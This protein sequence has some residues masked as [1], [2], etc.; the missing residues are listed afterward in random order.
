MVRPVITLLIFAAIIFW[1]QMQFRGRRRDQWIRRWTVFG[2]TC[3]ILG[4][5]LRADFRAIRLRRKTKAQKERD[6]LERWLRDE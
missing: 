3:I 1:F 4:R 5:Y 2:G 6:M